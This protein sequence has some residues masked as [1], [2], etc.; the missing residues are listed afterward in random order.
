M[1]VEGAFV[2]EVVVVGNPTPLPRTPPGFGLFAVRDEVWPLVPLAPLFGLP[3]APWFALL[4][5]QGARRAAFGLDEFLGFTP[6]D[7]RALG[8][9]QNADDAGS[10]AEQTFGLGALRDGEH[11]ALLLDVPAL[12]RALRGQL[13]AP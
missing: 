6:F 1:A 8:P 9:L 3:L 5:A 4:V 11:R 12:F 10:R 13:V 2:R 7:R